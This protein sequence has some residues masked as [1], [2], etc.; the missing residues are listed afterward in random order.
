M[1][2]NIAKTIWTPSMTRYF[3]ELLKQQALR[4]GP[5]GKKKMTGSALRKQVWAHITALFRLKFGVQY[6]TDVLKNRFRTLGRKYDAITTL[7]NNGFLWDTTR[8]MVVAAHDNMWNTYIKA[9]PDARS[10]RTNST[11]FYD[12]LCV[13]FGGAPVEEKFRDEEYMEDDFLIESPAIERDPAYDVKDSSHAGDEAI[14]KI[15]TEEEEAG[16]EIGFCKAENMVHSSEMPNKQSEKVLSDQGAFANEGSSKVELTRC[17]Y[18]TRVSW[19]PSKDR[20]F[21]DLMKDHILQGNKIGRTFTKDV[22]MHMIALFGENF[23][24]QYD[25]NAL[26]NRFKTL[27]KQY[28]CVKGLLGHGRFEWDKTLHM[29]KA[30]AHVWDDYVKAHPDAR[31]YRVRSVPYYKDL[32]IIYGDTYISGRNNNLGGDPVHKVQED[33]SYL[34]GDILNQHKKGLLKSPLGSGYSNKLKNT[35]QSMI[36]AIQEMRSAVTLL[37]EKTEETSDYVSTE[38][39]MA[40]LRALPDIDEELLLDAC[41]F[42][43]V[44][45]KRAKAF[46]LLDVS[47]QKKWLLRKLRSS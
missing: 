31:Q 10:Y 47:L 44:D 36:D 42:L 24:A 28:L 22:W 38:T 4:G 23:G 25:K 15:S 46:V 18:R 41:D 21:I 11:P 33:S 34:N 26:Y 45:A 29:V 32:C 13:I 12:D 3:I 43:E 9:H 5:R 17:E 27:R 6:H 14:W 39:W 8:H 30:D 1:G 35:D 19:T 2:D 37:A 7:L 16:A 20:Y 40:A